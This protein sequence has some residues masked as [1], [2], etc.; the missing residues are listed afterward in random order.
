MKIRLRCQEESELLS[1]RLDSE[2]STAD[3][4]RLR[5]HLV[6]CGACRNVAQQLEFIRRAVRQLSED[7]GPDR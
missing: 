6:V 4:A 7:Q 3:N 1:R 2:L 5:L